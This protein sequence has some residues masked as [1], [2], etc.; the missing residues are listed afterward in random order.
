MVNALYDKAKE[1]LLVGKIDWQNDN[2]KVAAVD[3][4]Y[5]PNIATHQYLS[6]IT[7]V[8]VTSS[9]L[10]GKSWT[11]GVADAAD[12]TFPTVTGATIVRL[13][14]YQDTGTAGTSR[15]IALYDTATGLPVTPD[16]TN[17]NT[18]WD[19]GASRI[20]RI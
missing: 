12:V 2:I 16:G 1:A 20:F 15:L 5:T 19:N 10:S 11:G 4:T 6:D 13:V 8:V 17:I 18:T 14:I 9:N 7:G 3:A